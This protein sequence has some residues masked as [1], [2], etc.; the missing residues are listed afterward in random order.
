DGRV[1]A[2]V[3]APE[4]ARLVVAVSYDEGWRAR[5]DG[6]EVP[7]RENPLAFASV[8]VEPGHHLVDL[9]YRPPLLGAGALLSALA[10]VVVLGL[11]VKA[12]A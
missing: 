12:R 6:V 9:S 11:A 3:D 7:V 2:E 8:P 10:L 1:R 4:A 5:V